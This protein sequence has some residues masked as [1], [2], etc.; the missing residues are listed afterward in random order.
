MLRCL[1]PNPP[2]LLLSVIMYQSGSENGE[3]GVQVNLFGNYKR[4]NGC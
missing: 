3:V 1:P 2:H 4:D